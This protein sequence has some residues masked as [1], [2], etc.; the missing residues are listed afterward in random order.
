MA[1]FPGTMVDT[2][3]GDLPDDFAT[4]AYEIVRDHYLGDLYPWA[5]LGFTGRAG[6]RA[7]VTT[8][9][10]SRTRLGSK[11]FDFFA[12]WYFRIHV[13]PSSI[14]LGNVVATQTR[15]ILVWN[16]F[17]TTVSLTDQVNTGFDGITLTTPPGSAPP[18]VIQPLQYWTYSVQV[19]MTGP[20]TIDA[21]FRVTVAG[22]NYDVPITGR[23]VVPFGFKPNWNRGIEERLEFRSTVLQMHDGGE[24]RATVRRKP[25]RRYGYTV[26]LTRAEAQRAGNALFGWQ[27][28]FFAAPAWAERSTLLSGAG[29][30][31]STLTFDVAYRS[32]AP[33]G[34]LA[35]QAGDG[36]TDV[37]EIAS[38]VDN[39]VTLTAPLAASWPAGTR[40]YPA[41]VSQAGESLSGVRHTD[42]T[43]E[44]PML[45]A[46]E[47]S[48]APYNASTKFYPSF[49]GLE[50]MTDPYNWA[51]NNQ[52]TWT[53]DVA[54]VDTGVSSKFELLPRSGVAQV[55]QSHNW[56]L[57]G[58]KAIAD[59][60]GFIQRCGGRRYPW[61]L[62]SGN[63]DFTL[64]RPVLA[65]DTALDV[66]QNDY[67]TQVRAHPAYKHIQIALRTGQVIRTR[68]ASATTSDEGNTRLVL[69]GAVGTAFSPADVVKISYLML[70]RFASDEITISHR[71]EEVATVTAGVVQTFEEWA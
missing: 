49:R 43:M 1:T 58:K 68:I 53:S 6:A 32:F 38:I 15:S 65:T 14:D 12:D 18:R 70:V 61:W 7:R 3:R 62:P 27:S 24:Q 35:L 59:F 26:L 19:D 46:V 5:D 37:R 9:P 11:T 52:P 39:T 55:A 56:T 40:V 42:G 29:A 41:F 71:T 64:V 20:P 67:E 63:T 31:T 16:A 4:N 28:R 66:L 57:R 36:P 2:V 33:G 60:K 44:L 47:P 45:L 48:N 30:G 21:N 50:V 25:R 54:V 34:L 69:A 23:R 8:T 17:L 10:F 51:D 22:L 13:D